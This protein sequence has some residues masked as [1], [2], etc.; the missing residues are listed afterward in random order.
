MLSTAKSR[1][2]L[3]NKSIET[4]FSDIL[5]LEFQSGTICNIPSV[6]QST[7]S[8][9]VSA[10]L[11]FSSRV[12]K[13]QDRTTTL[14]YTNICSGHTFSKIFVNSEPPIAVLSLVRKTMFFALMS[15]SIRC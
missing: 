12:L 4:K 13:L 9:L 10:G 15:V 1:L 3:G 6:N 8:D 2:N 5:R 14:S 11:D 7:D